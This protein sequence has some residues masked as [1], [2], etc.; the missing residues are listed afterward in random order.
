MSAM[1]YIA[2]V[3]VVTQKMS[4][5]VDHC[6]ALVAGEQMYHA[7]NHQALQHQQNASKGS[8]PSKSYFADCK[9]MD[10]AVV[11]AQDIDYRSSSVRNGELYLKPDGTVDQR[12]SV[13]RSGNV[14]ITRDGGIDGRSAAVKRGNVV[15]R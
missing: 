15:K 5:D 9:P 8:Q 11:H 12:S 4:W 7:N 10:I 3:M 2:P 13:V 1:S 14:R 6:R